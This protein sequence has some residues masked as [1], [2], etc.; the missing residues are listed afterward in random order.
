MKEVDSSPTGASSGETEDKQRLSTIWQRQK[1]IKIYIWSKM[2]NDCE[3]RLHT[4]D[5]DAKHLIVCENLWCKVIVVTGLLFRFVF[6]FCCNVACCEL[7]SATGKRPPQGKACAIM[8]QLLNLNTNTS[9]ITAICKACTEAR[10]GEEAAHPHRRSWRYE[11]ARV[12]FPNK[13]K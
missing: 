10:R 11:S 12:C 4:L 13:D 6:F 9:P 2:A 5:I 3:Q 7:G 1:C 8:I